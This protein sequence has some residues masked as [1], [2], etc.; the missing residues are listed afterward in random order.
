[1]ETLLKFVTLSLL[2]II[3]EALRVME[4]LATQ[5]PVLQQQ[6]SQLAKASKQGLSQL[7]KSQAA[8][9]AT[10]SLHTAALATLTAARCDLVRAAEESQ[11]PQKQQCQ[12]SVASP[13]DKDEILDVVFSCVGIG[14]YFYAAGVSRRWR[15][16]Y[17]KLCYNKTAKKENK[18][19]TRYS[20]A[21]VTAARL[22]LALDNNLT[23]A[24]LEGSRGA[25]F[26]MAYSAEPIKTLT[27]ARLRGI[28]WNQKWCRVAAQRH[29]LELLQWLHS[30]GCPWSIDEVASAA[31]Y[32]DNV[33]M[34]KW[35][36]SVGPEWS[37]ELKQHLLFAACLC[38]HISIATWLREQ[39]AQWPRSFVEL[40][41]RED[42]DEMYDNDCWSVSAVQL[43]MS[44]GCGWGAWRC[45]DLKTL[46][47]KCAETHECSDSAHEDA[48]CS[49]EWCHKK[50]A[51]QLFAWAHE[52]GC[53][54]TCEAKAAAAAAA[55]RQHQQQQLQQVEYYQMIQHLVE[56]QNILHGH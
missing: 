30:N 31:V 17:I 41:E 12:H 9:Q 50:W 56:Q 15:G 1:V 11:Q 54:C 5:L 44:N 51:E 26:G 18:L 33:D 48:D 27:V 34:L 24:A 22:Q 3:F 42:Y 16:R 53:P 6:L 10:L 28:T 8:V 37:Y 21:T 4:V 2:V 47:F 25:Y 35:L 52:H 36:H 45:R 46:L 7:S 43:A 49:V 29:N 55:Q 20:R 14:E 19:C 23:I 13:L 39:R 40:L 32:K 38:D